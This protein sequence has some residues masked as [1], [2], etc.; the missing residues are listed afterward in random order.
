MLLIIFRN[1]LIPVVLGASKDDYLA[2]APPGSFI[3]VDDFSSP[4]ELADYLHLLDGNSTL[5]NEYFRW[6]SAGQ[7]IDD[8]YWCRLCAMLHASSDGKYVHWYDDFHKWW[9]SGVCLEKDTNLSWLSW[10]TNK[11]RLQA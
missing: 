2:V 7:Y 1:D 3:H 10:K 8:K 4:R 9:D 5:Y 11:V 6:K